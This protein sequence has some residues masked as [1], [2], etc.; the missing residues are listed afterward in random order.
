MTEFINSTER[1]RELKARSEGYMGPWPP[2]AH[3]KAGGLGGLL[4]MYPP[5]GYGESGIQQ[6]RQMT[7]REQ[8]DY[9]A[10]L[11]QSDPL[12]LQ[13]QQAQAYAPQ[14][15]YTQR[16]TFN[17]IVTAHVIEVQNRYWR[18]WMKLRHHGEA[19]F[20]T[21]AMMPTVENAC[22]MGMTEEDMLEHWNSGKKSVWSHTDD[23]TKFPPD[24]PPEEYDEEDEEDG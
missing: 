2:E 17:A 3:I 22:F 7:A 14:H 18:Q 9:Y 1:A 16:E 10:S 19:G 12:G 21:V 6:A 13:Q 4:G 15:Q 5:M 11:Q 20:R 23:P 8:Q 24:F